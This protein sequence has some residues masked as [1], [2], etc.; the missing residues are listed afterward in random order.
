MEFKEALLKILNEK[1][2]NIKDND[3]LSEFKNYCHNEDELLQFQEYKIIK[4]A[5]QKSSFFV[6][7]HTKV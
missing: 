3:I 2:V 6:E 4:K 1:G 7:H 5:G